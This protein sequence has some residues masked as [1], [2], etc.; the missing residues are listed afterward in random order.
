MSKPLILLILT[1]A[2][3]FA[4]TQA[5]PSDSTKKTAQQKGYHETHPKN[6]GATPEAA[7][8]KDKKSTDTKH[9]DGLRT[10]ER[11]TLQPELTPPATPP[12]P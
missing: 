1:A 10:G 5:D 11:P 12:K 6:T 3:G 2:L 9:V 7:K 4:Q 8:E